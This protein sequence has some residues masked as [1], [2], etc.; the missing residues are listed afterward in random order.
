MA[1]AAVR[2]DDVADPATS[3]PVDAPAPAAPDVQPSDTF[4]ESLREFESAMAPPAASPEAAARPEPDY[5]EIDRLLADLQKPGPLDS[6]PLFR[7]QQGGDPQQQRETERP[8]C[9][10]K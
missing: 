8:Q 4:D 6:G 2:P 10:A 1:E 7:P 9:A 5:D 3:A